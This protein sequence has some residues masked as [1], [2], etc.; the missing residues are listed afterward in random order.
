MIRF[1]A[2]ALSAWLCAASGNAADAVLPETGACA[3]TM[4]CP[5]VGR[6]SSIIVSPQSARQSQVSGIRSCVD[7]FFL[8]SAEATAK[9]CERSL[10]RGNGTARERATAMLTLGHAY[11][12]ISAYNDFSRPPD[13]TIVIQTW[14]KA[15]HADPDFVD[16]LIAIANFYCAF[17]DGEKALS[18]LDLAESIAPSDWRIHARRVFAYRE[19][20]IPHGA[21][22]AAEKAM[23]LN[24]NAADVRSAYGKALLINERLPEAAMQYA[25]AARLLDRATQR[26][27]DVVRDVHVLEELAN[28]YSEMDKPVLAAKVYTRFMDMTH[29]SGLR[30]HMLSQR[31]G[32]FE[33]A[34]EL[35]LAAQDLEEA[36]KTAYPK[37][38]AADLLARRLILLSRSDEKAEATLDLRALLERGDLKATL[39]TQVFLRN[40]GY[41]EVSING[42][43]DASTQRALDDCLSRDN[44]KRAAGRAI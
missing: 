32:Y 29:A 38:M 1:L 21:L 7:W 31:A 28:I 5:G 40:Q 42:A 11:A 2:C 8:R 26:P 10:A 12:R 23:A 6:Q 4:S 33:R 36:A 22:R 13:D 43:Y 16:P 20:R 25:I 27:R 41:D 17:G 34:G 44:C 24:P 18:A 35:R 37:E 15:L 9:D 3:A 39:K 14:R 19:M 30:T